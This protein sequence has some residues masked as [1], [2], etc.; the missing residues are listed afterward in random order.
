MISPEKQTIAWVFVV[1]LGPAWIV[2]ADVTFEKT[3]IDKSFRSEGIAVTDVDGDGQGDLLAGSIWYQAP[4][5]KPRE[6]TVV[7][8]FLPL[9]GYS[10]SFACFCDDLSGDGR[11]DLIVVGYPGAPVRVYENP[12]P[13]GLDNHWREYQAFPSC[14]NE[15]P[16]YTDLTGD[17]RRELICGFEPEKKLGWFSP[18][19]KI[20]D[21]WTCHPLSGPEM[22]GAARYYHGLGAGDVNLDGRTDIITPEGWYEAPPDRRV[23]DWPFHREAIA[24]GRK[25]AHIIVHDFDDDGDADLLMSS[26]HAKGIWWYEQKH[27][28]KEGKESRKWIEHAIDDSCSQ[29]H[30][31]VLADV[32]G[33]GL[34][35]F[36]TGKRWQAHMGKDA[37]ADKP[38]D[39][40]AGKPLKYPPLLCWYELKLAEGK[41][42]WTRHVIDDDSGIGT[43]FEVTDV[44][45]DGLPDIAVANKRGVFYFEQKRGGR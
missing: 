12:G 18:R 28:G 41:P 5:W 30:A 16:A 31:M 10:E 1:A 14:C 39:I 15:S 23:P 20:S 22:P 2:A 25:A 11:P 17:G 4:E 36:V 44:N 19:G 7:K 26:A 33:D 32:N 8:E 3:W 24:P 35:D 34:E 29:T 13:A 45:G 6:L 9:K 42:S 43:Q 40:E 27:E 21:P 38:E 37:E